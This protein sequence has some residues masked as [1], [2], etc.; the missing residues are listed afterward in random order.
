MLLLCREAGGGWHRAGK[1]PKK[2]AEKGVNWL[3]FA[4]PS[5]MGRRGCIQPSWHLL[6][7]AGVKDQVASQEEHEG[8][9]MLSFPDKLSTSPP[10]SPH[11]L[12]LG[13][14]TR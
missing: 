12:L 13:W 14:D 3:C 9:R 5:I 6:V 2:K 4:F 1:P 8:L 10:M 11:H 7:P